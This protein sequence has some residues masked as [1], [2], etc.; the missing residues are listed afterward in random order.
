VI[1]AQFSGPYVV[2]AAIAK[3]SVFIEDFTEEAIRRPEIEQLLRI[4]KPVAYPGSQT[5]QEYKGCVVIK[6]R[7]DNVY[8]N[9]VT[10]AKGDP[11]NPLITEEITEKLNRCLSFSSRP[12]S[13]ENIIRLIDKVNNLEEVNNMTE[14]IQLLVP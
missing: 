7:N 9:E 8:E 6:T 4:T 5:D 13:Q 14:I 10:H 12:F 2:A 11:R 1:E 3:R